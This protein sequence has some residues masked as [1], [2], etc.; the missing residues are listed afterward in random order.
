MGHALNK[1]DI[2]DK[3]PPRVEFVLADSFEAETLIQV[4]HA[5]KI[6]YNIKLFACSGLE[7]NMVSKTAQNSDLPL[8]A[9]YTRS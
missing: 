8:A 4:N 7:K 1:A 9:F 5:L 6:T 2:I 3:D